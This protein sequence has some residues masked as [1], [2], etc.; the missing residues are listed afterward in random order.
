MKKIALVGFQGGEMCFLHLL[1]NAIEYQAKGYEV[2]VILEGATCGLIP[3]L[4]ARELFASKYLE[5]K[6]MIKAVC[7]ACAAQLGGLEA[8]EAGN[9]P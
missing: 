3:R 9:L 2:A 6:P 8:A 4:E 1:I 5:V 7:R